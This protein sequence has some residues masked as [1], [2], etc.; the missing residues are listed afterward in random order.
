MM[1]T[2]QATLLVG[3][4]VTTCSRAASL[5]D[6]AARAEAAVHEQEGLRDVAANTSALAALK[7]ELDD[8]AKR[9]ETNMRA[10][11]QHLE[12]EFEE[13]R[14]M[15]VQHSEKV[16]SSDNETVARQAL[17]EADAALT[18][19]RNASDT[20]SALDAEA[21]RAVQAA[22]E[23]VCELILRSASQIKRRAG[24]LAQKSHRTLD[25]LYSLG[26]EA[27]SRADALNDRAVEAEDE[28]IEAAEGLA[29]HVEGCAKDVRER[30]QVALA[31]AADERRRAARHAEALA[32]RSAAH[33]AALE[34]PAL[35]RTGALVGP[36]QDAL[37]LAVG[38]TMGAALAGTAI[39]AAALLRGCR[40]HLPRPRQVP[41]LA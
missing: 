34:I 19:M 25:P 4:A 9:T 31:G 32:E 8:V 33:L 21:L 36:P 17:R 10:R 13:F 20:L 23:A 39:A 6:A 14:R 35:L 3:M 41:L 30:M 28:T 7:R 40:G 1:P 27:E 16:S 12:R 22:T 5:A 38:A 11:R 29:R 24:H 26:D 2:T 18:K 37:P 15:A